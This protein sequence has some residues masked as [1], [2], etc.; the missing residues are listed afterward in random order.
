MAR[1]AAV[2]DPEPGRVLGLSVAE[3]MLL[4][5]PVVVAADGEASREWAESGNGG[6]WYRSSSELRASLDLLLSNGTGTHL[7]AQGRSWAER[8]FGDPGA[9]VER[10]LDA[11]GD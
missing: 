7:G 10:V 6:L 8:W 3:A 4:G 5:A 2:V 9:F 11:V 1:A